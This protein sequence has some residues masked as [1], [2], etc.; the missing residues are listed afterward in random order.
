MPT[1]TGLVRDINTK[2][3]I[4]DAY[5]Y[6]DGYTARTDAQGR[7]TLTMPAKSYN[8]RVTARN[9]SGH[10]SILAINVDG[11]VVIDMVPAVKML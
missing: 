9:Y 10:S 1:I 6:F 7:F 3:P 2:K 11:Q 4:A 8:L 5:V